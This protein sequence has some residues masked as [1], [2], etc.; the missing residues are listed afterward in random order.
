VQAYPL[1]GLFVVLL[2]VVGL[3]DR[4]RVIGRLEQSWD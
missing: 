3:D 4:A 2:G 1:A